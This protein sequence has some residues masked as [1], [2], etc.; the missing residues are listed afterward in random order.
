MTLAVLGAGIMGAAVARN[1]IKAGQQVRVWNRT[2]A[3]A[4]PLAA[5]GAVVADTPADA[6]RGLDEAVAR[7]FAEA[8]MAA[9]YEAVRAPS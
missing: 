8:D 5:D 4:E 2:R 1:W 3:G 7:G 9:I 6:V